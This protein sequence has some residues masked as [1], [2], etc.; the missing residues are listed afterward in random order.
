M[1]T[2][3]E[4]EHITDRC[5]GCSACFAIPPLFQDVSAKN[6]NYLNT[7][8]GPLAFT[9]SDE[10]SA[11][12]ERMFKC[13]QCKEAAFELVWGIS[14]PIIASP[15]SRATDLDVTFVLRAMVRERPMRAY[16]TFSYTLKLDRSKIQMGLNIGIKHAIAAFI[17]AWPEGPHVCVNCRMKKFLAEK[18]VNT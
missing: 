14:L 1:P 7:V 3:A 11:V 4:T 6:V 12:C 16:Q 5:M 13:S 2:T 17:L 9:A 15:A 18:I 8:F 10:L